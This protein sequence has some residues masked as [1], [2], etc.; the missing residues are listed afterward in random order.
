MVFGGFDV[1]VV[2][3]M[4]DFIVVD[5]N[6]MMMMLSHG[7]RDILPGSGPAWESRGVSIN[8]L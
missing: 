1:I 5:L 4:S 7:L 2:D 3:D 8:I 6:M